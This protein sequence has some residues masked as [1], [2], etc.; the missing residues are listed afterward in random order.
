MTQSN[1][2]TAATMTFVV[3]FD[4][5]GLS[6]SIRERIRDV[7]RKH[8]SRVIVLDGTRDAE[9][10]TTSHASREEWVEIPVRGSDANAIETAVAAS[11]LCEAPIVLAWIASTIAADERF[12]VLARRSQTVVCNSSIA[13]GSTSALRELIGFIEAH[14]DIDIQDLAY[15][16]LLAWQD[17]VAEF[18]DDAHLL[19]DL[20][21]LRSV[22]IIAG[23]DAEAY[24]FMGW[25]ASRLAWASCEKDRMCNRE[26]ATIA[27][28]VRRQGSPGRIDRIAL[29]TDATTYVAEVL[30]D[31][32]AIARVEALGFH[33]HDPR[34]VPLGGLD[35]AS[36]I[37]RAI[38]T[39]R[40]PVFHETIALSKQIIDT[41]R[42]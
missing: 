35:V 25:L 14:P 1:T 8:P 22:E 9:P 4:D 31:D 38:V 10:G 33:A 11:A 17:I 24:Y 40:D 26:G 18:F 20:F 23:S 27:F 19:D 21:N 29:R 36:L 34:F 2:A 37:A 15:I 12:P 41:Q 5:A 28:N 13:D 3:Y 16:R 42:G 32:P 39:H 30:D 7:D 6:D